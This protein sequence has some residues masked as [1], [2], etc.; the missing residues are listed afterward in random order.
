MVARWLDALD[1]VQDDQPGAESVG[2]CGHVRQVDGGF[3][4]RQAFDERFQRL[5]GG[6]DALAM[7]LAKF[8]KTD[9]VQVNT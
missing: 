2:A 1:V 8:A 6:V 3:H 7:F 9:G 5:Q 4:K